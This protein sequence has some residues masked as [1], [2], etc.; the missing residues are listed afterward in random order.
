M[1]TQAMK[2]GINILY[3]PNEKLFNLI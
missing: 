1:A 2:I 3:S